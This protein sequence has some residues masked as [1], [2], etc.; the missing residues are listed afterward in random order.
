VIVM[1]ETAREMSTA[2]ERGAAAGLRDEE[3]WNAVLVRDVRLDGV[4][5]YAVRSTGIYCRPSCPARRPAREQVLFFDVPDAAEQAG[6]RACRRCRPR[7]DDRR[8]AQAELVQRACRWI[9]SSSDGPPSLAVLGAQLGISPYHLH[10]VFT[11]LVG[12]TPRQYADACRLERLKAQLREGEDVT[13]ALYEAGY[14]SSARVYERSAEQFGM[15]PGTYGRGGRG[16]SIRYTIADCPLGRLLVG[17]TEKGICAVSLGDDDTAL[18]AWLAA[19]YP[20]AEIRPDTGRLGQWVGA[21]VSHLSGREPHLGLP[22]DVR[23]TAF[24]RQVWEAL[25]A[26]PAG[27]T[28]TYRQIA[29]A[30]GRPTAARAVARACAT[31]PV[32]V[33]IPCHRV[34]RGDGG[35]GGYRWGLERKRALLDREQPSEGE[36]ASGSG[37][38]VRSV[39]QSSLRDLG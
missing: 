5:V 2:R 29:Q 3:R 8:A 13:T 39:N 28:R 17:A 35:L 23:A 6:F 12:I 20:A 30:I 27:S 15:T 10:R 16:M 36:A 9:E 19:E 22:V 26:I 37:R 32:A 14:S 1:K 31:N 25:G 18:A 11:R 4:F 38:Q 34:V 24:Q 21:L 33:V 7:E